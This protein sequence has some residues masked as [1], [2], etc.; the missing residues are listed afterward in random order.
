MGVASQRHQGEI[1]IGK[2]QR[3]TDAETGLI[4]KKSLRKD[5]DSDS[6]DDEL[7]ARPALG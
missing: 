3:G 1:P 6:E 5:D 7:P 2:A 4:R